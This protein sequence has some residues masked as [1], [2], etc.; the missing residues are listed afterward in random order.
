MVKCHSHNII[1]C[2]DL[3]EKGFF[4]LIDRIK[5]TL[6]VIEIMG[7]NDELASATDLIGAQLARPIIGNKRETPH[8]VN[9]EIMGGKQQHSSSDKKS[10]KIVMLNL[11]FF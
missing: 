9:F 2:I 6:F 11:H 5:N 8:V 3:L 1:L 10:L 4:K 7:V